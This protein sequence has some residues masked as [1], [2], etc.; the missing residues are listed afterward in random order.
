LEIARRRFRADLARQR[1]LVAPPVHEIHFHSA[2]RLLIQYGAAE[3]LRTLD[4][5]QLAIAL[6]LR[7]LGVNDEGIPVILD[8]VDQLH[9]LRRVL[10]HLLSAARAQSAAGQDRGPDDDAS[11]PG[12]DRSEAQ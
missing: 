1:I 10:R 9:G 6:D 11:V 7:Q 8:L 2:R 3:G 5:L 12:A 4:A